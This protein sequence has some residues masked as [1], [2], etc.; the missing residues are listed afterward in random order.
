LIGAEL[1]QQCRE[2]ADVIQQQEQQ[3]QRRQQHSDDPDVARY[4]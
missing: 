1:M 4:D 3:H 2:L